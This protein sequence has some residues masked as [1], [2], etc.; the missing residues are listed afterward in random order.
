VVENQLIFSTPSHLNNNNNNNNLTRLYHSAPAF[1]ANPPNASND[2]P[3][4]TPSSTSPRDSFIFKMSSNSN[5]NSSTGSTKNRVNRSLSY[6]ESTSLVGDNIRGNNNNTSTTNISKDNLSGDGFSLP[7]KVLLEDLQV[8]ESLPQLT[9]SPSKPLHETSFSEVKQFLKT[10]QKLKSLRAEESKQQSTDTESPDNVGNVDNPLQRVCAVAQAEHQTSGKNILLTP[11]KHTENDEVMMSSPGDIS[12]GELPETPG[13]IP[14]SH[15]SNVLS[16]SSPKPLNNNAVNVDLSYHQNTGSPPHVVNVQT[17]MKDHSQ[18]SSQT[19]VYQNNLV[20]STAALASPQHYIMQSPHVQA[21]ASPNHSIM[22]SHGSPHQRMES[23]SIQTHSSPHHQIIEAMHSHASPLQ[24]SIKS[25]AVQSDTSP[26]HHAMES[27]SVQVH[28]SPLSHLISGSPALQSHTTPDNHMEQ[29]AYAF[30]HQPSIESQLVKTRASPHNHTHRTMKSPI[31]QLQQPVLMINTN[32][33][34]GI[35]STPATPVPFSP[36]FLASDSTPD[37][38]EAAV[39]EECSK[40]TKVVCR[41]NNPEKP[42]IFHTPSK[43]PLDTKKE[44]NKRNNRKPVRKKKQLVFDYD[45]RVKE[46]A[47]D[48]AEIYFTRVRDAL[49]ERSEL[50]E[51]FFALMRSVSC[52]LMSKLET[53]HKVAALLHEYP[54]LVDSFVG[55]LEQHEARHIGKVGN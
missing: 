22:E 36:Q 13:K 40:L 8:P 48:F 20:P 21:F 46:R 54:D 3:S 44:V 9:F 4:L 49:C 28:A 11:E 29:Q 37:L 10:P 31:V 7:V 24:H 30:Q 26:Y 53:Y 35:T 39:E 16:E 18:Y 1:G 42:E 38:P 55:F 25:Q 43:G 27:P 17:N 32:H 45:Q 47:V 51:A 12:S 5:S 34:S 52:R 14:L 33:L 15:L 2:Q 19:P 41:G 50:L 6:S 23:L